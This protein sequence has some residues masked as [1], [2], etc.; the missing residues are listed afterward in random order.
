MSAA[1]VIAI[2]GPSASGK[3][4]V[5]I[6]VAEALGFNFLDSG[7]L[8]RLVGLAALDR[9]VA[10]DDSDA[11]AAI[12]GN[13]DVRFAGGTIDLEGRD[14]TDAIR[15]ERVS[16]AASRVAALQP[17]RDALL[18]RQRAFREPPGLVA[19]GRDMGSVVF[20]D[21]TLKI[22][23][24]ADASERARRRY[25]QLIEKGM[26]ANMDVLLQEIRQ[27]DE[28][29]SQRAAAPLQKGT[30][31]VELDTTGISV[32]AAVERVLTLYRST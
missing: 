17:V 13:L 26:T 21:A 11:V 7:A 9:G 6:K 23:L 24:T 22:F 10:L 8:Y 25:K 30:D 19:D 4:T 27:R 14:V 5:A 29:D 2:D 28:R 20:P 31:A 16:G 1:P 15:A 18:A 12:A 3:G 32:E